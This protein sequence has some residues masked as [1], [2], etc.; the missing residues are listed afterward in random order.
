[1]PG[2]SVIALP[3][4][5]PVASLTLPSSV[6]PTFPPSLPLAL[7]PSPPPQ[8]A[9]TSTHTPRAHA[10]AGTSTMEMPII[11]TYDELIEA[12]QGFH[13]ERLL[14]RGGFGHVYKGVLG[15]GFEVAIKVL[16]Q[17]SDQGQGEREYVNEV[18]TISRVH[19]RHLVRL[20]GFCSED[21][22]RCLVYE[23]VANGTLANHLHEEGWGSAMKWASRLRIA[24]GSAKGL[25]YLHEACVPRIVHR[26]IKPSNILLDHAFEAKIADFGLA[27]LIADGVQD[28]TTRAKQLYEA[29]EVESF[30][31]PAMHGDFNAEELTAVFTIALLCL[32][33]SSWERPTMGQVFSMLQG[34]LAPADFQPPDHTTVD[35]PEA[36]PE[37]PVSDRQAYAYSDDL[38][39]ISFI[40]D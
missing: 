30:A 16:N 22:H 18:E 9:L 23:Y 6:L 31:D 39:T 3:P 35:I 8:R 34:D 29:G 32:Q 27:K 17:Q 38:P 25:A 14:G 4:S 33:R 21:A 15:Q 10:G 36:I 19:H 2:C 28:V 12:T 37:E 7:P 5:S 40:R 24:V 13:F 26:D 1:M 20:V 11:F